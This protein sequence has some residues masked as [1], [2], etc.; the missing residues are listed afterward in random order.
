[1]MIMHRALGLSLSPYLKKQLS[2][3]M[4]KKGI[5]KNP[6]NPIKV[7][8]IIIICKLLMPRFAAAA[9]SPRRKI[10][11]ARALRK[12]IQK[13][14]NIYPENLSSPRAESACRAVTGIQSPHSGVG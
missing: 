7:T 6:D 5:L 8:I 2:Q 1:M 3:T 10:Y 4:Q 9:H 14:Q 11:P 12:F 13:I